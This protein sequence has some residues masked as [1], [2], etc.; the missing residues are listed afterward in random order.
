MD[1]SVI[2]LH[3]ELSASVTRALAVRRPILTHLNQDSSWLIQIPWQDAPHG[4]SWFNALVDPWFNGEQVDFA[5]CFSTQW[6][7]VTSAVQTISEL[8]VYLE[9][10]ESLSQRPPSCEQTQAGSAGIQNLKAS[11]IDAVIVSHEFTDHCNQGTL[12]ELDPATP[13]FA[14]RAAANTIR[15][16]RYFTTVKTILEISKTPPDWRKLSTPPLPRWLSIFRI[17]QR[18]D[19]TRTHTAIVLCFAEKPKDCD[20]VAL[21]SSNAGLAEGLIYSPHGLPPD[22][23]EILSRASPPIRPLVLIH[24]LHEV[25]VGLGQINLGAMNGLACRQKCAAKYW[26]TTHDEIKFGKG[27]ISYLLR[28]NKLTLEN[29]FERSRKSTETHQ[30]IDINEAQEERS[31]RFAELSSGESLLLE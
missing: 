7:V 31:F 22:S 26:V 24:G 4:R 1:E 18:L 8:K 12:L 11:Y 25:F 29:A 23:L 10:V 6:H 15:T 5:K 3:R 30:N 17:A 21:D 9:E 14:N 27:L 20:S 16:W 28:Y 13:I 2:Q 19:I